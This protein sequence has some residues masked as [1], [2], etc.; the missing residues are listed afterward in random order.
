MLD[1]LTAD[2]GFGETSR[3]ALRSAYA[4][5]PVIA[6]LIGAHAQRQ[7]EALLTRDDRFY[8][9]SFKGLKVVRP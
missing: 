2:D 8:R 6:Y 5:G 3:A 1:V 4:A 9:S 7:A